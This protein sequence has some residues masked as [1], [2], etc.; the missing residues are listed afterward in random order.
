M[1]HLEHEIGA[2]E[3][4]QSPVSKSMYLYSAWA[5]KALALK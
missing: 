3:V 2:E 1:L 5:V 4:I